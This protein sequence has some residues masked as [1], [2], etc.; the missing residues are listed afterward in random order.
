MPRSKD[1]CLPVERSTLFRASPTA[2]WILLRDGR[3]RSPDRT[4]GQVLICRIPRWA[5]R[6]TC[7]LGVQ[8]RSRNPA[9][10]DDALDARFRD[11]LRA[12]KTGRTGF[13]RASATARNEPVATTIAR[14]LHAGAIRQFGQGQDFAPASFA[15]RKHIPSAL[16]IRTC[17][18]RLTDAQPLLLVIDEFGKNLEHFAVAGNEG[19][20]FLLQELAEMTQGTGAAPLIIVTMQHLSFDEY[21]QDSSTARRKE[22]SKVQG[23]FQDIPYI[24]TPAQSRR[25]IA[26]A[27]QQHEVLREAA[28]QWT[29]LH[30]DVL[31]AQGLRDIAEDAAAAIPLHPLALAVLP[32]L[33]SR[34]GQNERT[35]FS[36][37][38]SSEPS[39]LPAYLAATR[40]APGAPLPLVGID[41]LYDYFLGHPPA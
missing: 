9:S 38:T 1:M 4:A 5:G 18:Q 10:V 29:L 13:T 15:S 32:D 17:V 16:D 25:L 21:V 37:L 6:C 35:L 12:L 26:S 23:R 31:D 7:E 24:E 41:L 27:I 28:S 11:G 34:Y 8:S 19:D 3:S 33:C 39:A 2:S 36:F 14:A 20:P 30:R 22:W 40:W